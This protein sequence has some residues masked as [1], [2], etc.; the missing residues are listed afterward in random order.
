MSDTSRILEPPA[1]DLLELTSAEVCGYLEIGFDREF[2]IDRYS[3]MGLG[4]VDP[5]EHYAIFG[6]KEGRDPCNWFSTERYLK[7]H[8]D[9]AQKGVNPLLHYLL[10]GQ[11]EGRLIWPADPSGGIELNVDK[12]ATFVNDSN[13][14]EWIQFEQRPL[15]PP[16]VQ[17]NPN[18]MIIHWLIPDFS[19]GSGGHMTIFRIVRWLE[20]IGHECVVWIIQPSQHRDSQHAYDDIVKH[21]QTIRARVAFPHEGLDSA[22]GDIVI[23]TGWQT[24]PRVLNA[25]HFRE[26]FYFVQDF[27]AFFH[28]MGTNALAATWTYTQGLACICAGPW[29]AQMLKLRFGRWTKH[30]DLAFDKETYYPP[31]SGKGTAR[32]R[33]NSP[34]RIVLYARKG[35]ARRAVELA[36]LALEQMAKNGVRFHVSLFGGEDI[37]TTAPFPC[38]SYGILHDAELADL[39][40]TVD[41]GICFSATNYSLVPQ[42]MMACGLPVVELEGESTRAVFPKGVVTLAGPHPLLIAAEI[43]A[44]LKDKVRRQRQATAA[45]RW[46][47]DFDWEKSARAVERAM[48]SRLAGHRHPAKFSPRHSH[49]PPLSAKVTVCIPTYNGGRL[50]YQVVERVR[51]QRT[52]WPF[53]IVIVDSSSTDGSIARLRSLPSIGL[54]LSLRIKEIPKA[55]FQHGRTRNMCADLASGEFV[56]FLTQDALPTDENWLYNMITVVEHFPRSAGAFGRHIAWPDASPFTK[57]DVADHFANLVRYPLALS[58]DTKEDVYRSCDPEWRQVLHYFSDNNSCLRK[59]VWQEVPYPELDYGEDQAW[60]DAIIRLGYQKIYAPSAVVYHS[61]NYGESEAA[62][63]AEIESRYFA[64]TF[65]HKTYDTS[66]R[67][68]EQLAAMDRVDTRWARANRIPQAELEDRLVLN[69]AMLVGRRRGTELAMTVEAGR[70]CRQATDSKKMRQRRGPARR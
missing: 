14:H 59:S 48:L 34:P 4:Y 27:E 7:D 36:L 60:A 67:F 32:R 16:T 26:R 24:V 45:L 5:L 11:S 13:L 44:L 62:T 8:A 58:R 18:R 41:I 68:E 51:S 70:D 35:T 31:K 30:F 2:Y 53:E 6:W 25:I 17:L 12:T 55:D 61:H 15:R 1:K 57:R 3:D 23:A 64:S 29:L 56:A 20:L 43:G 52:P 9:V 28:P 46:V 63:R 10:Y 65:G 21:F 37:Y 42:E 54:N 47:S 49:A 50:L 66:T 69:K 39:Y 33:Q 38:I 22:Q 19:E 40:R